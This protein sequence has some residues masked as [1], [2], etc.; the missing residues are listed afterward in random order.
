VPEPLVLQDGFTESIGDWFEC[1]YVD[2]LKSDYRLILIDARG[3]GG[4]DR[5]RSSAPGRCKSPR[6]ARSSR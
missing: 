5:R 2:A 1:G 3:Q 6:N 4:S